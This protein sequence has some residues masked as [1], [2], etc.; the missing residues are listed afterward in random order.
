[1]ELMDIL[2]L[3][4]E[5]IFLVAGVYIYLF[6]KGK[7]SSKDPKVRD[8]AEQFRTQNQWWLRLLSLA[9]IAVM[10]VNIGLHLMQLFG[11]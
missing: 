6:S 9:M 11:G 2:G 1:M 5:V 10:T 3:A 8:K 4:L 7:F